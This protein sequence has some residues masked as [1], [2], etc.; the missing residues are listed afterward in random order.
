[1]IYRGQRWSYQEFTEA[2]RRAATA[3]SEAGLRP[4]DRLA[5]MTYNT[6]AFLFADFDLSSVRAWIYGAGPLGADIAR[7]L[8]RRTDRRTSTRCTG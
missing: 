2:A 5:G 7:R 6:P 4:G 8:I 1:M 3:L